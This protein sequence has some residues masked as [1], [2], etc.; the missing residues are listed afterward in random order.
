MSARRVAY[1]ALKVLS[2]YLGIRALEVV[3]STIAIRVLEYPGGG[4][5]RW[6]HVGAAAIPL[7]AAIV[8]WVGAETMAAR[9]A[10]VR[11]LTRAE[12]DSLLAEEVET[13][14]SLGMDSYEELNGRDEGAA[15]PSSV[16]VDAL[17]FAALMVLGAY[18]LVRGLEGVSFN[19]AELALHSHLACSSQVF[20]L[21]QQLIR[22]AGGCS[23]WDNVSTGD[24]INLGAGLVLFGFGAW[25]FLRPE[26]FLGA[27][28]RFRAQ[29]SSVADGDPGDRDPDEPDS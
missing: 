13:D 24:V 28:E 26:R 14:E 20:P 27:L 5:S 29:L 8:L 3:L 4:A 10:D 2:L 23:F 19:A 1:V 6:V 16:R 11:P 9:F 21:S 18:F 12:V 7:V 17:L 22:N 25:L 15:E